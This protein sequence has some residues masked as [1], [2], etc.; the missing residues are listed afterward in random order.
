[1]AAT[2]FSGT[3]NPRESTRLVFK[4]WISTLNSSRENWGK[5]SVCFALIKSKTKLAL[6]RMKSVLN[7]SKNCKYEKL[8]KHFWLLFNTN[9]LEKCAASIF[10]ARTGHF[11]ALCLKKA[12]Q[13]VRANPHYTA[14]P[15]RYI[16]GVYSIFICPSI[17]MEKIWWKIWQ[18]RL[19]RH[20]EQSSR[21]MQIC[22]EAQTCYLLKKI[23]WCV[24]A[25]SCTLT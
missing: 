22:M 24:R 21:P 8:P 11:A 12:L 20:V 6:C 2:L 4:G 16:C 13:N 14:H 1:M 17:I 18:R 15:S 7:S 25:N 10:R 3:E 5:E 19:Q 9:I 23:K